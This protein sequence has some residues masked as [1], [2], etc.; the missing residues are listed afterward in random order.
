MVNIDQWMGL[1]KAKR[2]LVKFT[3]KNCGSHGFKIS[4]YIDLTTIVILIPLH[5][6]PVGGLFVT[7]AFKALGT[8]HY[9]HKPVCNN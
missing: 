4:S 3:I 2:K 1:E 7:A 5:V 6:V 8:A 9:L